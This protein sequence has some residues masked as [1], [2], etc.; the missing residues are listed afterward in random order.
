MKS[1]TYPY[2]HEAA[3]FGAMGTQAGIPQFF[4]ANET[5]ENFREALKK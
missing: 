3:Q 5:S 2:A 1:S 4:H